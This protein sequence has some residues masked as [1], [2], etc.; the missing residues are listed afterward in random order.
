MADID[1]TS[2]GSAEA[3]GT[4]QLGHRISVGGIGSA[5]AFGTPQTGYHVAGSGGIYLGSI[6]DNVPT[7]TLRFSRRFGWAINKNLRFSKSFQWNIG[8]LPTYWFRV[9]GDCQPTDSCAVSPVEYPKACGSYFVTMV[10][11]TTPKEV[12]QKLA[13]SKFIWRIAEMGRFS[14]PANHLTALAQEAAGLIDRSCNKLIPVPHCQYVDCL[15]FCLSGDVVSDWGG[16]MTVQ[17]SFFSY[18]GTGGMKMDGEAVVP[19]RPDSYV[20]TGGMTISGSALVTA[21]YISTVGSGG[22]VMGGS[23]SVTS[24]NFSCIG[25]GGIVT[26]GSARVSSTHFSNNIEQAFGPE[27]NNEFNAY[28]GVGGIGMGGT[29]PARVSIRFAS[30]G[31]S[32]VGPS[33]AGIQIGGSA[34]LSAAYDYRTSGSGGIS[35]GGSAFTTC[36]RFSAV[37][38]GGMSMSGIA[39][40]VS[41]DH[42]AA[43]SGGTTVGG[44]AATRL[45]IAVAAAGGI[46]MGG[47]AVVSFGLSYAGTGGITISGSAAVPNRIQGSGGFTMAG[48]AV[49]TS[50]WRGEYVDEWG[51][52]ALCENLEPVFGLGAADEFVPST[53][54]ISQCGATRLPQ[55]LE[56]SHNFNDSKAVKHFF[57]RNGFVL[58]NVFDLSYSRMSES[59]RANY[60]YL[61]KADESTNEQWDFLI[62]FG[63]T[64]EVFGVSNLPLWKFGFYVQRKNT[65]TGTDFDTRIVTMFDPEPLASRFNTDGV[66]LYIKV[67]PITKRVTIASGNASLESNSFFDGIGLF[68]TSEWRVKPFEF[69]L[70]ARAEFRKIPRYDILP[71]FPKAG[72][73][74]LT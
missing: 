9:M 26:V 44:S 68:S 58:P 8:Q 2:I 3:F 28:A 47:S 54:V 57:D 1:P 55:T 24:T 14:T 49:I 18:V 10:L 5:E 67:N 50:T 29:A 52:E 51:M 32:S 25:S 36:N 22:I 65:S 11:A 38:S 12:C 70:K 33:F 17:D 6:G 34:G 56:V 59:W 69:R 45:T 41:P 61:G 37:G 7:A 48:S 39:A 20:G 35:M 64:N 71:I 30:S 74:D 31:L 72:E 4:P 73:F 53:T 23:A 46:S 43:G 42:H 15:P 63:C 60:H 62:E 27:F 40:T 16:E 13:R 21:N 19:S 66:D